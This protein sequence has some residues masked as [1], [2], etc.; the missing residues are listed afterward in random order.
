M[1]VE[2]GHYFVFRDERILARKDRAAILPLS[3]HDWSVLQ[4]GAELM[5]PLG[6]RPGGREFAIELTSDFEIGQKY[7]W[8]SL[9]SLVGL[10]DDE[11]FN[12]WGRAAQFL[13]WQKD[14]RYCGRCGRETEVNEM[15]QAK[16]CPTCSL[17][18]Y[19]RIS[20]CAI[21]LVTRAEELLLARSPQ[22]PKKMYSTLAGFVEPGESVEE[23]V[24]REILE[25]VAIRVRN[26]RY[27]A[28]QPWP[29]PAQLMLGFFAEYDSGEIAIDGAEISEAGWYHYRNLPAIPG[30][31]T[32][33]GR[34]I[35]HH[36]QSLVACR[37]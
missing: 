21:V 27:F 18:W 7:E 23:T 28:S 4:T 33:A 8:L 19:P 25:E 34:M 32:I 22:F 24:H 20:P 16:F 15:E 11:Q 31:G 10:I 17:S 1:T 26:I 30:E 6:K 12:L 3:D 2:A 13:H 37:P 35:R 5:L 36:V 14:H 9:R 29:F